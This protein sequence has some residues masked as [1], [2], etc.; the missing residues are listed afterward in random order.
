MAALSSDP[1]GR[2]ETT[3]V[4]AL[5]AFAVLYGATR[6]E[7]GFISNAFPES[8]YSAKQNPPFWSFALPPELG[9]VFGDLW[10]HYSK[11][12]HQF[13]H[14]QRECFE[15]RPSV[16]YFTA[17]SADGSPQLNSHPVSKPSLRPLPPTPPAWKTLK[18]A[19]TFC[20]H[21]S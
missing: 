12:V 15:P 17:S 4:R 8:F 13:F 21:D 14:S 19:K 16:Y 3:V 1:C 6:G 7:C 5:K 2:L 18:T 9:L 20:W 11:A 10:R